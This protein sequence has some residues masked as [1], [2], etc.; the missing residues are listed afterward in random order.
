MIDKLKVLWATVK[1]QSKDIWNRSK[2]FI[3]A[4]GAIILAIE[5]QKIKQALIVYAGKKEIEKD[6]AKDSVLASQENTAN[7]QADA[8]V[9]KAQE[10]PSKE[11][12]VSD[13]WYKGK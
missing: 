10:E 11:Q 12:P 13:D 2:M 3:I 9:Q 8:L 5:F 7:A 4:I 1:N 6:K